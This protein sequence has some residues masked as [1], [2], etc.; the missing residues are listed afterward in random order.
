MTRTRPPGSSV[1]TAD[2]DRIR[3]SF[4]GECHRSGSIASNMRW[5]H[6]WPGKFEELRLPLRNAAIGSMSPRCWRALPRSA[7]RGARFQPGM[8][9]A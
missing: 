2:G 8:Y 7:R 3:I 1:G 9:R 4:V 6:A 5:A